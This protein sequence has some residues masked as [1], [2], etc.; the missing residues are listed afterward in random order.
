MYA[1]ISTGLL[2]ELAMREGMMFQMDLDFDMP[3]YVFV[4]PDYLVSTPAGFSVIN[5]KGFTTELSGSE[6]HP[7]FRETR[8]WLEQSGY[9][10]C[11]RTWVNGDRVIKP[12]YFNNVYMNEGDTFSCACAMKYNYSD[13]YIS[14]K[15]I[16]KGRE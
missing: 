11:Q 6:D 9:I 4:N 12:F 5:S 10:T 15:P 14:G 8:K 2:L 1:S 7:F 16:Y 3:P 13:K